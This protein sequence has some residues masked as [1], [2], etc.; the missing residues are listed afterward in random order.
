MKEYVYGCVRGIYCME[1][2]ECSA[3]FGENE[4]VKLIIKP[5]AIEYIIELTV[6][7]GARFYDCKMNLLFEAAETE[8][9]YEEF[10]FSM[11]NNKPNIFFGYTETIDYYPH[12]DGEHDRWGSKYVKERIVSYN[13]ATE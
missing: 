6:K 13:P 5:D 1:N 7:G 10:Y 11:M 12:C 4:Q 3:A 2:L 8:E 9:A